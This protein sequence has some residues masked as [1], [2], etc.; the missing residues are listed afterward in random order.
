MEILKTA[1]S[2][3][4]S[5]LRYAAGA[6]ALSLVVILMLWCNYTVDCSGYFQGNTYLRDTVNM[7][8]SGEDIIGYELLN[9][10]QR[11]IMKIMVSNMDPVPGTV[12]LGSSRILQLNRATLRDEDFFNCALT[13]GDIA[14]VMGTFYLFDRED[15]LPHTVIIGFDPWLLRG[16]ED[17]MD[18]RSDRQLYTEFLNTKLG[19]HLEYTRADTSEKWEALLSLNYFQ[20]NVTYKTR[21]DSGVEKPQPV[22]GDLYSQTTEVKCKD[23]SLLYDVNFR[24]RSQ[25]ERDAD[26]LYQTE[27]LLH[28]CDYKQVPQEMIDRWDQFFAY[29]QSRGVTIELVLTPYHPIAY[30]FAV[31][32]PEQYPGFLATEPIVRQLAAKY[33]LT[34]YGSYNPHAIKGMT[35]ADFYDGLHCTS[36]AMGM[37][38]WGNVTADGSNWPE[39]KTDSAA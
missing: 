30:D 12:A 21:D 4:L 25:E 36:D 3:L 13:G 35:S 23:G 10:S 11:D 14:D 22:T 33:G 27:N 29:A 17:A 16:G 1:G 34:V 7:L 15:K 38:F 39:E 2:R 18:R 26:A 32:H 20:D 31:A 24:N 5:L 6:A 9:S 19:Y 28:M 37:L 8:L